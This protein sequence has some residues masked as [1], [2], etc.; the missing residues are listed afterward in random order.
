[1]PQT[2]RHRWQ[3]NTDPRTPTHQ[4]PDHSS[5]FHPPTGINLV[6][7]QNA[8]T[9]DKISKA[10]PDPRPETRNQIEPKTPPDSHRKNLLRKVCKKMRLIITGGWWCKAADGWLGVRASISGLISACVTTTTGH[11]FN[12]FCFVSFSLFLSP[13]RADFDGDT[14]SHQ[15]DFGY[16]TTRTTY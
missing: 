14:I 16:N 11:L 8:Q 9:I 5:P 2:Q 6:F 10:K 7:E 13:T 12:F 3:W 1:M 15:N 4:I